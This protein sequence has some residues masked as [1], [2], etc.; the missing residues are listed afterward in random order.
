MR[1]QKQ[2]RRIDS[3]KIKTF[4][5]ALFGTVFFVVLLWGGAFLV[6][7]SLGGAS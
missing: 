1:R 5:L 3:P 7:S 2:R 4:R 6:F